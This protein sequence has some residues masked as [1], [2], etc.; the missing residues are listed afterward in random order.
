MELCASCIREGTTLIVE[1]RSQF[2]PASALPNKSELPYPEPKTAQEA[3]ANEIVI[4]LR[5]VRADKTRDSAE[6]I[7]ILRQELGNNEN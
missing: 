2:K 5:E 4:S 6:S 3:F 7:G 1:I